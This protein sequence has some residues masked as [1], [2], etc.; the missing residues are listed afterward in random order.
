MLDRADAWLITSRTL[1]ATGDRHGAA[2]AVGHGLGWVRQHA[3]P[4]V[5]AALVDSFLHRNAVNRELTAARGRRNATARRRPGRAV[6]PR[7]RSTSCGAAPAP[8]PDSASPRRRSRS[9][10]AGA[11]AKVS[12]DRTPGPEASRDPSILE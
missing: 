11:R 4:H 10:R 12:Q 1:A 9:G 8:T 6:T 7:T 2:R 3:L 5:P